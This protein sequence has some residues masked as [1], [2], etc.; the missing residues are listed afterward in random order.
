MTILQFILDR[1]LT[2]RYTVGFSLAASLAYGVFT[3]DISVENLI[4]L[5]RAFGEWFG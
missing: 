1:V 5:I 4:E 3:K 2:A